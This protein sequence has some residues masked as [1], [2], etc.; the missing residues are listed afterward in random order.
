MGWAEQSSEYWEAGM[1]LAEVG[2]HLAVA[3]HAV[4]AVVEYVPSVI[5][6]DDSPLNH[7]EDE[8]DIELLEDCH[9]NLQDWGAQTNREPTLIDLTVVVCEDNILDLLIVVIAVE[10]PERKT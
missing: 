1:H 5:V 7:L 6:E 8:E 9:L 3:F 10:R 4:K 2:M